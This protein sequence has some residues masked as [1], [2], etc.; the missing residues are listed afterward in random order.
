MDLEIKYAVATSASENAGTLRAKH[1]LR[2]GSRMQSIES[3]DS[4]N[5]M[6]DEYFSIVLLRACCASLVSL[7]HSRITTTTM[8]ERLNL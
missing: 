1:L 5:L 3:Q 6:F 8:T 7:W 4:I 2:I